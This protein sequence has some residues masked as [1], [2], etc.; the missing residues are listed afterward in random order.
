MRMNTRMD[1]YENDTPELKKRTERNQ[2]LYR[3]Y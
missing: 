2:D 1:K 3:N